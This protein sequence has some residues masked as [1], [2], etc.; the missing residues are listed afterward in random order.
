MVIINLLFDRQKEILT[1]SKAPRPTL[2]RF[3]GVHDD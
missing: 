1:H 3:R 2:G